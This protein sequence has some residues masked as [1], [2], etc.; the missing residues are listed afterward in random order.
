MKKVALLFLI[1][2]IS[3]R[4]LSQSSDQF[5]EVKNRYNAPQSSDLREGMSPI[6][7]QGM[8]ESCGYFTVTSLIEYEFKK[9]NIDLNISEQFF[10]YNSKL[11]TSLNYL[12]STQKSILTDNF[13]TIFSKGILQEVY[14]PYQESWFN[15]GFPC[16]SYKASKS[17]APLT[18]FSENSPPDITKKHII[19]IEGK[20]IEIYKDIDTILYTIGVRNKPL[21]FTFPYN[22]DQYYIDKDYFIWNDTVNKA[23]NGNHFMIICGYNIEKQYFIIRNSWGES[24]GDKGCLKISFNDLIK[25]SHP[26][27]LGFDLSENTLCQKIKIVPPTEPKSEKFEVNLIQNPDSSIRVLA[28]IKVKELGYKSLMIR[29]K[30]VIQD[31]SINDSITQSNSNEV[32]LNYQDKLNFG[33]EYVRGSWLFIPFLNSKMA[34][35][36]DNKKVKIDIS[37]ELIQSKSVQDL[38]KEGKYR[39]YVR[40]TLYTYD[41]EKWEVELGYKYHEVKF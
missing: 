1:I 37:K 24:F 36:I 9:R 39:F 13:A 40:T 34:Q 15:F 7:D 6:K 22:V 4:L 33:D 11:T 35:W 29:S 5:I 26:I 8:K 21:S 30:L 31:T 17:T 10:I 12:K 20:L 41:D 16:F 2:S 14:W 19:K 3:F 23:S 28:N 18:C 32:K 38:V 27:F 25:Y